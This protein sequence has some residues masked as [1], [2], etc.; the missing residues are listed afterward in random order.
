V[1]AYGATA[2]YIFFDFQ[3]ILHANGNIQVNLANVNEADVAEATLG[4]EDGLGMDGLSANFNNVGGRLAD[5]MSY[6]FIEPG[7][8]VVDADETPTAFGLLKAWP[9]PFN[10]T[11]RL[12][13]QLPE[14]AQ[15]T[16]RLMDVAGRQVAVLASGLMERGEHQLTVDASHLASGIYFAQVESQGHMAVTKL[17]LVR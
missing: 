4:I 11:T 13:F 9:N 1:P 12:S 3:V 16:V 5:G 2:P 14:T 17:T 7:N 15:A 6:L 8:I 10:P